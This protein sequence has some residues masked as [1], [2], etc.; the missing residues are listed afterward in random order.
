MNKIFLLFIF[1]SNFIFSQQKDEVECGWYGKKT[2]EERNQIFPFNTAK[3]VVYI[4]FESIDDYREGNSFFDDKGKLINND[5]L[6]DEYLTKN[7]KKVFILKN[8]NKYYGKEV[9]KLNTKQ[10]NNLSNLAFNFIIKKR[11][12]IMMM[13]QAGC[14]TPRNAILFLDNEEKVIAHTEICFEC[15]Q[16]YS[17]WDEKTFDSLVGVEACDDV[18]M[19]LKDL[20]KTTG[21]KYGIIER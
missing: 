5:S 14:Y 16:F 21:I 11:P 15:R 8:G 3:K 2:V 19:I 9:E 20:F 10:I 18:F 4:S 6:L 7:S 1:C 13:Y 17:D 12:E